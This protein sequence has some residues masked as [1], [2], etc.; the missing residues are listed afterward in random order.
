MGVKAYSLS[1]SWSRIFPFGNGNIN[2]AGLKHYDDVINT[3]LQYGIQSQVT[4]YHWDLPL[5]LQLSYGGWTSEE[6]VDDFVAYAKV[7]LERWGDR[8]PQWYSFNEPISFCGEYPS[9]RATSP[10]ARIS[11]MS[12]RNSGV[13]DSC[14]SRLDA[15][16]SW[17]GRWVLR[18]LLPSRTAAGISCRSV[19]QLKTRKPSSA[20]GHS[21]KPGSLTRCF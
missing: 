5:Y 2:E 7:L 8:V 12:S 19:G 3:C 1:I 4:M 16:I 9:Q 21:T 13:V 17:R 20:L 14:S 10:T 6:I 11:Q 18:R 15:R